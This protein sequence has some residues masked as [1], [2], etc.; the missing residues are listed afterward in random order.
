M[1]KKS[2]VF[3]RPNPNNAKPLSRFTLVDGAAAN[4]FFEIL[5]AYNEH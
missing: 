2:G 1:K 3:E 4:D 5:G